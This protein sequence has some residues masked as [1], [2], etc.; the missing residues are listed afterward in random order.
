MSFTTGVGSNT[1]PPLAPMAGT[2]GLVGSNTC[3]LD[4]EASVG[5]RI[6]DFPEG[7]TL[8]GGQQTAHVL[9]ENPLCAC[10]SCHIDDI[11]NQPPFIVDPSAL[12]GMRHRLA[13][14]SC[15]HNVDLG[16]VDN[17]R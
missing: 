2:H 3:P 1:P 7:I 10:S 14:E 13:R 12:T 4:I 9:H 8:V 11:S 5:Q 15:C 6:E 16:R 17:L